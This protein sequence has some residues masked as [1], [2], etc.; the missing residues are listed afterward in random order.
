M[1]ETQTSIAEWMDGAHA[2]VGIA[3]AAALANERL[4][5]TVR[6]FALGANADA[7]VELAADVAI[8]LVPLGHRVG[9]N[10]E[11][12]LS[13]ADKSPVGHSPAGWLAI[14][15]EA[16]TRA[17]RLALL[18]P[19]EAWSTQV[20]SEAERAT[21]ALRRLCAAH[22]YDLAESVDARMLRYRTRVSSAGSDR[23]TTAA[24]P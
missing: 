15:M 12:A 3:A 21:R 9:R 2:P 22:G 14:A 6:A 7:I 23:S 17:V 1:R 20:G 11:P 13:M 16:M 4:A 8:G 10:L 24:A 18:Q 19:G 5:E